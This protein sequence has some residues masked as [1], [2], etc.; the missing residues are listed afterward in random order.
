MTYNPNIP[1]AGTRIDQTYNLIT[2]NFTTCNTLFGE[3][4]YEFNNATVANRGKHRW[5]TLVEQTPGTISTAANEIKLYTR[6]VSGAT[7]LFLKRENLAGAAAAIPLT[8]AN[9]TPAY[10]ANQGSTFIAGGFIMKWGISAPSGTADVTVTFTSPFPIA[11]YGVSTSTS[12][13]AVMGGAV[14]SFDIAA[15]SVSVTSF[16]IRRNLARPVFWIAIGN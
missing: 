6:D 1:Q 3:D 12:D 9:I 16:V 2:T 13:T 7:E 8:Y 15:Y 14:V 5:T 10:A 11:C 4:H